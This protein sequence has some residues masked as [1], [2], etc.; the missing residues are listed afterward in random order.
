MI[1]RFGQRQ[2]REAV[3]EKMTRQNKLEVLKYCSNHLI[4][5]TLDAKLISV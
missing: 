3:N 1:V 5:F 2:N 4:V